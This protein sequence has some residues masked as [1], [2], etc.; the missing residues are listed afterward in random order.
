MTATMPHTRHLPL[1][2][3]RRV[4]DCS[5]APLTHSLTAAGQLGSLGAWLL[6][7]TCWGAPVALV[8]C[9]QTSHTQMVETT[10]DG[11]S[12]ALYN[13]SHAPL[14]QFSLHVLAASQR[15]PVPYGTK[16]VMVYPS[17]YTSTAHFSLDYNYCAWCC[18]YN[19]ERNYLCLQA[20]TG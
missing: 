15:L 19:C 14:Q 16:G 18:G 13:A 7:G 10:C 4:A 20:W 9:E 6:V 17:I 5:Q 2:A 12:T 11:V 3:C 8:P 1:I